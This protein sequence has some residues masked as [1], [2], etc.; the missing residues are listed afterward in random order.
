MAR[1]AGSTV[2]FSTLVALA[3]TLAAP[4]LAQRAPVLKQIALP[5][6]YYY[7][8]MYLPQVTSGPGSVDWSPDGHDL[9][10]SMQGSLWRV[11]PDTGVATQITDGPGYDF[12][13]DFS[14]DGRYV[15]YASYHDDAI[16]LRLLETATG[17]SRPLT[18]NGAVN[19]EP[20][21]APDGGRIAFVSTLDRGR[22][23]IHLLQVDAQGT[24]GPIEQLTDDHDSGLPRYYY[25]PFD[26]FLSPTWS[27]DG[28]EILFVSNQGHIWGTG[29]FWRM[30]ARPGARAREVHYEE[31]TWK[32]RPDWSPDG[33]RIVYSSYLGR[34]WH[35]LWLMT[36]EGGDPFPITYGDFDA[37]S[38]RWSPDGRRI[39]YISNE[40]GNTALVLQDI[41]GG[42]RGVIRIKERRHL[43]PV[44]LLRIEVVT[45]SG[46]EV[47][48][49]VSVTGPDGR[50][51]AP[52]DAWRHAD[53]GF[54][55]SEGRYEYSYFHTRG[56]SE[57]AVP[58]GAVAIEVTRGLE[59]RPA[60]R[61]VRIPAG[62][63]VTQRISLARL[64]T[65]E[66]KGWRG[67]DLHVH[68]NYAGAYRNNPQTLAFQARAEGLNVV[69]S[70][71]VNKEQ[72]IPDIAFFTGRPDAVSTADLLIVHGQEYHTSY[73]GH[74]ALLGL[75]DHILLPAYAAYVNTP[76]A[77]LFP[78]NAAIFDLAHAQGA[79]TGYVHPFESDPDP[80]R[81]DEPLHS[82]LPVD[83]ALG[84]VDYLEVVGFSD[85]L[86][87]ARVW[88]RLLNCGFRIPAGAGTDAMANFA[89]LRGPVGLNRVYVKTGPSLDHRRWLEGIK[90]GRTFAT[91]GPLLEFTL[92]GKEAGDTV[93][94]PAAG[95]RL[96]VTATL[97]SIV[98]VD[99]LEI[100]GNG[101]VVADIP[102]A[103][104]RT[105]SDWKS[106]LEVDRSG[107]YT[108]R[109]WGAR[110]ARPI[111]DIY[112]F[113]TTSPVYVSAGDSPVH[114]PT[115][116][117]YFA[118]W[119]DRLIEDARSHPGWNDAAE[120][121]EVMRQLEEA[122]AIYERQAEGPR[123][124]APVSGR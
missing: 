39:A 79:I 29:G 78:H 3:A 91:N 23:H 123:E 58:A 10:V 46:R 42:R 124:S 52:D 35:Q 107:W 37:T 101:E 4:A 99:H 74:T 40:G 100:V 13:P 8:E 19:V 119:I 118:S 45:A 94:L 106:S 105:L 55:R 116:A 41:P 57:L 102:L 80:S 108:L 104:D 90:S 5:H 27:P 1:S 64:A 72:R 114:S 17:A 82:E 2:L 93:R 36:D 98:P 34:P 81:R 6:S 97:R 71:I 25:S 21:W 43:D 31:T 9:V 22:F 60:R 85:H 63:S 44:G 73:W 16:E 120:S 103:G 92:G 14:P 86:A 56:T 67:G 49:R 110:S 28:R 87:T 12:Q 112:P 61:E 15:A 54:D 30:K 38:P 26:H 115:D 59:Y 53:D 75:S 32:A 111:L 122:K 33:R 7:R 66:E 121:A 113:A 84:K 76:A 62:G 18:S 24:P 70:L 69:E 11:Q 117:R 51:Y 109:A 47:P 77:S 50:A 95:G 88:Y 83:V 68:M 89:S 96:T 20:R 48:A 65:P